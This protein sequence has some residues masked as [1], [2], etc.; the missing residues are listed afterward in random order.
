MLMD[1][2]EFELNS[3]ILLSEFTSFKTGHVHGHS[4]DMDTWTHM[5]MDTVSRQD[6]CGNLKTGLPMRGNL[7][8]IID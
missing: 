1:D 6:I 2:S 3:L 5:D 4:L 7:I 8:S